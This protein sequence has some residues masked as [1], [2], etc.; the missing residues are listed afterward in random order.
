MNRIPNRLLL[1]LAAL[2][3]AGATGV[4]AEESPTAENATPQSNPSPSDERAVYTIE[5]KKDPRLQATFLATYISTSK[6]EACSHRNPSTA[7]RK[8][9][10]GSKN[11]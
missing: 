2:L 3:L 4:L 5:G 10:I 7:T 6:S 9:N 1:I 11:R 8:V